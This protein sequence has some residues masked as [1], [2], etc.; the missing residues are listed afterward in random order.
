MIG[1]LSTRA[2]LLDRILDPS[3]GQIRSLALGFSFLFYHPML[4]LPDRT[5]QLVHFVTVELVMET[6]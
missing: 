4:T 1:R 3:P 2:V 6:S 5:G